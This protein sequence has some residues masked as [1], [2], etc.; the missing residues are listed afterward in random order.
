MQF[1]I[2]AGSTQAPIDRV[3]CVTSVFTGR[4]GAAVTRTAWGR[5][6]T[7]TLITSRPDALLEYGV[8]P[9][10]PGDRFTVVPFRTYDELAVILQTRLKGGTFD[11]LCHCAAGGEFLPAGTFAPNPGTFFN[12]RTGEWEAKANPPLLTEQR[13]GKIAPGEPELWLRLVRGPRLIDRVRNPWGFGGILVKFQMESGFGDTELIKL[14]EESRVQS[15]ADF[16]VTTTLEAA[17]HTAFLGPIGE[18]YDRVPRRELP[19]RIVLAVESLYQ[20]R[21]DHG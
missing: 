6:H 18:R 4:T 17:T 16:L 21:I 12:A 13:G 1:L 15:G 19:D 8:N 5:G 2:T 11:A 3:R 10:D 20:E 14:A 9:R 7:V